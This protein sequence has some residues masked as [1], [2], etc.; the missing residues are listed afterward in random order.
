MQ[1]N[2]PVRESIVYNQ[3]NPHA[4]ETPIPPSL[5]MP[6]LAA[7]LGT[8]PDNSYLSMFPES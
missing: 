5:S 7:S 8:D 4:N 6:S 2:F 1:S 3:Q